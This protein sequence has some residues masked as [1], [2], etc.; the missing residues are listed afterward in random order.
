MAKIRNLLVLAAAALVFWHFYG[1]TLQ[2]SGVQ[3]VTEH[4][5]SDIETISENPQVRQIADTIGQGFDYLSD[6]FLT[7]QEDPDPPQETAEQPDLQEPSEQSFS[8]HNIEIG[9]ERTTVEEQAGEPQR[10]TLNEYGIE[11]VAYHENYQNFF[12]AAYDEQNR[13]AGLYTNQ[14]LLS[15][16][17]GISMESKREEVQTAVNEEPLEAIRKGFVRYQINSEGEYDTYSINNNYV[18]IFY[19][20]HENNTVT[21]IQ[22]VTEEMEQEKEKYFA[23]PSA[24]LNEGFAYQLFDLTNAARVVHGLAPLTWQEN[25][26]QTAEDHS[27]DM[28]ENNYFSHTNPDGESPFDRMEE[29]DIVFRL[30]GENLAAG[31]P[32]SIFAHEGL[33][34]SLG[35]RENKLHEGFEALAVGIAFNEESQPYYT[36]NYMAQ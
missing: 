29:D 20:E 7:G 21:A 10:S 8:I 22:I 18:T 4:I 19:D 5:S 26:Q 36:E 24:E 32:S 34:N 3:G 1:D 11:W 35:H 2:H 23:Q 13:V 9:D 30:A 6:Q 28:A 12:M 27:I 14:D 17:A 31:Q 25:L 16:Q 33:M 15:S